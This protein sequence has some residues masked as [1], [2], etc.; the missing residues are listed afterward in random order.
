MD[1]SVKTLLDPGKFQ[2]SLWTAKAE[3]RASVALE[4]LETLWF[5]TG[6]LCNLTCGNC[7]IESSP[8]N[9]RLVYLSL[10][11]VTSYLDE[12]AHDNLGT[13]TIGFTGGEPFMNPQFIAILEETLTRGFEA[14]VLTNAMRPMMKQAT[15]LLELQ[16]RFADRLTVRV[17]VDHYTKKLHEAERGPKS[18]DPAIQGLKWLAEHGFAINIAGRMFSGETEAEVRAGFAGLFAGLGLDLDPHDPWQLVLFPEMDAALDVPEITEDCWN[19]LG[20]SP[21]TIMCASSRMVVKR[22][23]RRGAHGRLLHAPSLRGGIRNGPHAGRGRRTGPAQPS[24]LR[25]LL[26]PR[27]RRLF[28]LK[29]DYSP[30]SMRCDT[31]KK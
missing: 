2:D 11:E 25:T 3:R 14:L 27:R 30:D 20:L 10:S 16:E 13:K 17:S 8:K 31:G 21:S 23:G 24:S 4:K 12:I 9:D 15:P 22:K 7:Y 6:T 1:S 29:S 18:W 26:R 28:G 19:I 5:N